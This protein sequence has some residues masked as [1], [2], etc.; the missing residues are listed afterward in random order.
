MGTHH[1]GFCGTPSWRGVRYLDDF[2]RAE[3][4]DALEVAFDAHEGQRRKS[5]EPYITHPV[6]VAAILAEMELDHESLVAGLLHDT[7]EDTQAVTFESLEKRYGAAV[8]ELSKA[9]PR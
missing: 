9:R 7:V 3:V 5:G 4:R 8:G 2:E 1:A 6:A